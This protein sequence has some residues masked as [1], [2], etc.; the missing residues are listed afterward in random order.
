MCQDEI[1]NY[2]IKRRK[3]ALMQEL[4]ANISCNRASISR[5]CRTLIKTKELKKRKIKEGF[6]VK[7]LY[8]LR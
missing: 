3:P 7:Y 4:C 1:I 6:H 5:S 8:T 2:L